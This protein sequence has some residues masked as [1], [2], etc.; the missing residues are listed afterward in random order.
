M[1]RSTV[2]EAA[3]SALDLGVDDTPP[4]SADAPDGVLLDRFLNRR[5]EAAFEAIVVRHG[6]RVLRVCRRWLGDGQEADDAF[7]ATFLVLINRAGEFRRAADVGAWLSGVARRVAGRAKL[8]SDRRRF[9]E[10]GAVDVS[11]VAARDGAAP[12]DLQPILRAEV[13]RLPEKYRRPIELCYWEGLSSEQAA[14]RLSCPTGTLKWRLSRAR[15]ILRGRLARLGVALAALLMMRLPAADAA[16]PLDADAAASN[17]GRPSGRSRHAPPVDLVGRTV[18]LAVLFMDTDALK[19]PA[20]A[21]EPARKSKRRGSD[22]RMLIVALLLMATASWLLAGPTIGL[23][24]PTFRW[25]RSGKA[26]AG[27][28]SLLPGSPGP[29]DDGR[30]CH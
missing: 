20:P 21:T 7:Q 16:E 3:R 28:M 29:D 15:E 18:R 2:L 13:K 25:V 9:R 17:D 27:V 19:S 24:G 22:L 4:R 26:A 30:S 12:D 14:E 1:L 10:G 5:D 23:A 6:P 11:E 8:R